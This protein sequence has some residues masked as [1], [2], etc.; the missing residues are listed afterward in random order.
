MG[1][2]DCER[3][4]TYMIYVTTQ[5]VESKMNSNINDY[6]KLFKF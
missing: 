1:A 3:A 4:F 2:I 6:Y 5:G